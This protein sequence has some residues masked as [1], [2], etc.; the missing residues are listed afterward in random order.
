MPQQETF[1]DQ[2]Q[3]GHSVKVIKSYDAGFAKEAFRAMDDS[4]LVFL[5]RSFD[6][7]SKYE[8]SGLPQPSD[9]DYADFLWDEMEEEAR[10]DWKTFSYFVVLSDKTPLFVSPD[11][12]T[13]EAF[14]QSTLSETSV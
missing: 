4:A 5:G 7:Q 6:L 11:W 10:E 9:P 3:N 14:V 8:A 13:A 12:P 1:F 2:E